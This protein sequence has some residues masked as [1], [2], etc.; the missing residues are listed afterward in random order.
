MGRARQIAILVFTT[1][2]SVGALRCPANSNLGGEGQK[3]VIKSGRGVGYHHGQARWIAVRP[4][5]RISKALL[6]VSEREE[7]LKAKIARLRGAAAKGGTYER[8]VGK[9]A[10]LKDKMEQTARNL[11]DEERA[12]Q[13]FSYL[14]GILKR[15]TSWCPVRPT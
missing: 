15:T 13:V 3:Y 10:D 5:P 7:E 12:Q 9:G 1:V 2:P 6:M 4:A 11:S 8:V 14:P